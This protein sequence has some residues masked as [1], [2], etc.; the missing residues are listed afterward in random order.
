MARDL[1]EAPQAEMRAAPRVQHNRTVDMSHEADPVTSALAGIKMTPQGVANFLE[2]RYGAGNVV[3]DKSGAFYVRPHPESQFIP[4]NKPGTSVSDFTGL[5]G[6]AIQMLPIGGAAL[7]TAKHGAKAFIGANAAAGAIGNLQRQGASA[8]LPGSEEMSLQD[9]MG[10][11]AFDAAL[12]G[13]T[14]GA[15][16]T[17]AA[18]YDRLRLRNIYARQ[19][20]ATGPNGQVT[21]YAAESDRIEQYLGEAFMPG[22]RSGTRG[23]LTLEGVARRHPGKAG[24]II[25]A[26]DQ[27]LLDAAMG[28]MENMLARWNKGG[29][30]DAETFGNRIQSNFDQALKAAL[31]IRQGQAVKDFR[32]LDTAVARRAVFPVNSTWNALDDLVK[33][34]DIEGAAG[35]AT[36]SMVRQLRGLRDAVSGQNGSVRKKSALEMQRLLSSW[37]RHAAGITKPFDKIDAAE[38]KRIAARVFGALSDDLDA[39]ASAPGTL[40]GIINRG[41]EAQAAQ[42]L[43][44]ARDNYRLNSQA[45]DEIRKTT[46][47]QYLGNRRPEQITPELVAQFVERMKPSQMRQTMRILQTA[48]PDLVDATKAHLLQGLIDKSLPADEAVQ[49]ALGAG[50]KV[51]AW[52]PARFLTEARKSS[53]SE[54]LTPAEKYEMS[55]LAGGMKRL[56]NRAGTEGSPTAP[57]M[58]G[59]E[60]VKGLGSAAAGLDMIS[61]ARILGSVLAPQKFAEAITNDKKRKALM[62]LTLTKPSTKAAMQSLAALGALHFTEANE[63]DVRTMQPPSTVQPRDLLSP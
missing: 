9:R 47:G 39:A 42:A 43:K 50:A 29:V 59:Y 58:W 3:T 35:D 2:D 48:D 55:L 13:A 24:D 12:G 57:L 21:P 44:L 61:T 19:A 56:A 18:L 1:F 60:I 45:I 37:G 22:Q 11:V 20:G 54:I 40:A 28:N 16:R 26:K 33:E 38:Q 32:V 15:V 4:L 6:E 30:A 17:G 25:A 14:A 23:L 51:E 62:T 8:L 31:N 46:I 49:A 52:S 63:G 10:S 53:I 36:K 34:Y 7:A 41:Q 27:R 5:I